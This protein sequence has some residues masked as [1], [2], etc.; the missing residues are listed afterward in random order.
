MS[1]SQSDKS[2]FGMP[3][4]VVDFMMGGV[5]AAVSKTAAAPIERIKLLIQNQDE[6]LRAGRLDR[7]YNGIMD[8]FRR[9]AASEGV[10]SLWRGNTANVIRY[11]PTQALNFAFRDTYKSMFAYKK[12]RDGYAKWMMGNLASGGAAGA[13]SLLFVYSLDYARTRLANDA[14]SAKGGGERQF[15]G[16]VDVYKKTLASDG[17]AGLYRGFGPSVLGI[18]VYRGLYFGMYDSIKPVVLVGPLEGNFLA[19]FLLGWTVT[20]GAGIA[21]YPLDTVRRRMMMTSGEAVK[22][23]S[24]FDAFRQIVAKEGVKSLFKGAGANILRGVAGAGVLSIYDQVQ[25]ILFG[26]KFK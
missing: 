16:L 15:N 5:S 4:F 20:T 12:D 17:I 11:F 23:N 3:G 14:K 2:V 24:S 25:L 22:Y 13:T 18:V 9:T 10:A 7:K 6:M 1:A 8:C 26:K 19:S 21:S